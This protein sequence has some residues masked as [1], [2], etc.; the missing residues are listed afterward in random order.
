MNERDRDRPFADSRGDAFDVAAT[1]IPGS[2][3]SGHTAFQQAG[4]ASERPA[5]TGQFFRRKI[6]TGFNEAFV[7]E[8]DA[9]L[10]PGGVGV[11]S[12]HYE[13]V[14]DVLLLGFAGFGIPPRNPFEMVDA[15]EADDFRM[16]EQADFRRLFNTANEILRRCVGEATFAEQIRR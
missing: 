13:H 8:H 6:G 10:E 11:R 15:Y 1:N 14:S 4:P 2:E 16:S 3:H 12:C 9:T 7:V 5:R